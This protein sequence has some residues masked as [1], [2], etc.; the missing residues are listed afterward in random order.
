LTAHCLYRDFFLFLK[1]MNLERDRWKTFRRLY[2]EKH[3]EFLSRVWI[4]YHGLTVKS[5]RKRVLSIEKED[6]EKIESLLK[7]Y[8]IEENTKE[9]ILHC[10]DLLHYPDFCNIYL[11][12]G[13]MGPATCIL[14]YRSSPVICIALEQFEHFRFYPVVLSRRF[15]H[16]IQ[17][18]RRGEPDGGVL[19]R[20]IREGLA[21][22]FSRQAFPGFDDTVYLSL[23]EDAHR[24]LEDHQEEVYNRVLRGGHD[25]DIFSFGEAPDSFHAA[26][27]FGYTILLDYIRQTGEKRTER[28]IESMD[29]IKEAAGTVLR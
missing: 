22:F 16:Y 11:F 8:D 19:E 3:R 27:Y 14:R 25:F 15:C 17:W 20:L 29:R 18:I 21:V 24:Y 13:F 9:V 10:R 5:I 7:V 6:Y 28:L 4:G 2:Y 12:I 26:P 23:S 1:M